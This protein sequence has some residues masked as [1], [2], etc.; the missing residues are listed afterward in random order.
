MYVCVL[1]VHVMCV[2]YGESHYAVSRDDISTAFIM[3]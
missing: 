2:Y 3:L 1:C